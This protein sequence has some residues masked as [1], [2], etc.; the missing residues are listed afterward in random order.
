[1]KPIFSIIALWLCFTSAF[2]QKAIP[3]TIYIYETITVYDTIV[4]RDTIRVKK[5]A[6]MPVLQPINIDINESF[7]NEPVRGGLNQFIA[8]T[9]LTENSLSP[10]AT[11]SENSII[12]H[13]SN[14]YQKQKNVKTMKLDVINYLNVIILTAQTMSGISTQETKPA[15]DMTT[16]PM[17]F[18]I[19]Y[20]MTTQGAQTVNYRYNLSFNLLLGK[21]GA[22]KGVEFGV[23]FNQV[24]R[25]VKGIQF[26]GLANR[27]QEITGV[28]FGGM[29]NAAKTVKGIQFGGWANISNDITGIQYSGIAN[30]SKSVNGIQ[31]GGIANI[32]KEVT[33]IQ[34][35]GVA[36]LNEHTNGL[37]FAGIANIT[38]KSE[39][40]QFAGV[41][42]I[43]KEVS[44]ASF[45]GVFNR[46]GTLRGFQ[47]GVVNVIDTIESGVSAGIINIVKKN[48]YD[49]WSLSF[50]DYQNVGL[51]YK[52]G[53]QKFYTIFTA[54]ANFLEDKLWVFGI[55]FGN[56]TVLNRRFDFQPEIVSYQYF[57]NN[58]RNIQNTSATYLKFGFAY[59]FNEK[60]G[61]VVAP[62]IYCLSSDLTDNEQIYKISPIKEFYSKTFRD[63]YY[64]AFGAGISVGLVLR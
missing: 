49:E 32:C 8:N 61:I 15:E 43:S 51:S 31:Y 63:R 19:V 45:G 12:L 34:F 21:V 11:F 5:A 57:P 39:G 22:V 54:G 38:E 20:P 26:G 24:E 62:S 52:M 55:G 14:T 7:R 64:L 48:F 6:K 58:F 44:G 23:L 35:G 13:E 10:P 1:M 33:G 59:K 42:N 56:R 4:I 41:T 37:Q 3:D 16:F 60:L 2:A 17:Q 50:A 25:D 53:T 27:T 28:Q 30:I 36:N 47:F 29:G 40:F 46:T 18:C 9:S